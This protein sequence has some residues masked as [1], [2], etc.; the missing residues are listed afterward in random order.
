M[1][2]PATADSGSP[3]QVRRMEAELRALRR[4]L[5]HLQQDVAGLRLRT[6]ELEQRAPLR[7]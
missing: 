3:D 4:D 2:A 1:T 5:A 6:Q 7:R